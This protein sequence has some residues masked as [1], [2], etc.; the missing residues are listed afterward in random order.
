M[1]LHIG[2]LANFLDK[3][4][5]GPLCALLSPLPEFVLV[6]TSVGWIWNVEPTD[7]EE[8]SAIAVVASPS[9]GKP[10]RGARE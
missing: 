3:E 2:D 1:N 4:Y 6:R 9:G 5:G 8:R 7:E 10:A